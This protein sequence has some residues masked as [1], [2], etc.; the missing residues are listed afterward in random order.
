MF[1]I[2]HLNLLLF[3]IN[4]TRVWLVRRKCINQYDWL[5]RRCI[6]RYDWYGIGNR[7]VNVLLLNFYIYPMH[8]YTAPVLYQSCPFAALYQS[9]TFTA[10]SLFF[11]NHAFTHSMLL[12]LIN[13]TLSMPLFLINFTHSLLLSHFLSIF[14]IHS[15]LSLPIQPIYC[16]YSSPIQ[17]IHYSYSLPIQPIHCSYSLSIIL[18]RYSYSL[19]IQPINC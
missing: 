12:F 9:G 7:I 15:S 18:I 17:P 8:Q 4:H 11:N 1:L 10:T 2:K 3:L 14:P 19:P 6:N 13:S 5:R 16:S